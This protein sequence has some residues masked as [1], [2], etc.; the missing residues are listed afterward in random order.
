MAAADRDPHP[1][2][3]RGPAQQRR[4]IGAAVTAEQ[5]HGLPGAVAV[6]TALRS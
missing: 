6:D 5:A 4:I 2:R 3:P 1:D